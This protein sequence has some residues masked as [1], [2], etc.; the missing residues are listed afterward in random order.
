MNPTPEQVAQWAREAG[1]VKCLY[2][3]SGN[4]GDVNT[5]LFN[6]GELQR[7][8]NRAFTEGRAWQ[9]KKDAVVCEENE[10]TAFASWKLR[11]DPQD[12]G[13]S[14]GSAECAAAIRANAPKGTT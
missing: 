10:M 11:A 1:Q 3:L 5:L 13:R 8:V 12:Q 14:D 9:A 4:V 7:L 2:D 6:R